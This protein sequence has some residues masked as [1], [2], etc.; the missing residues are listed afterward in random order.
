MDI[1]TDHWGHL[2]PD[3]PGSFP[4]PVPA[5]MAPVAPAP[6]APAPVE[7]AEVVPTIGATAEVDSAPVGD[8]GSMEEERENIM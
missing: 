4:V 7:A 8:L 3:Q 6:V 1:M 5:V 2:Y